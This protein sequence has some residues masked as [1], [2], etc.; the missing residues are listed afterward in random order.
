MPS[1]EFLNRCAY[2]R[3]KVEPMLWARINTLD[4]FFFNS[5]L[6]DR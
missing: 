6:S 4:D 5:V 2:Q 3:A 1:I